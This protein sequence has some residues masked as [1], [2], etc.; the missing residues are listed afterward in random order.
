MKQQL[1]ATIALLMALIAPAFG[2]DA[3]AFKNY[4]TLSQQERQK[5]ATEASLEVQRKYKRWD[6]IISNGGEWWNTYQANQLIWFKGLNDLSGLSNLPVAL[7][8]RFEQETAEAN[9][10]SGMTKETQGAMLDSL[11]SEFRRIDKERYKDD[12]WY[13]V[14]LAPTPEAMALDEK[15]AAL[16]AEWYRRLESGQAITREDLNVVEAAVKV[17]R[18]QMRTLPQ[19]SPEQMEEG[20]AAS[21]REEVSR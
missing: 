2:D 12:W 21:S 13:L 4:K 6:Q 8:G 1:Y 18:D 3:I 19:W 14:K 16:N 7:W 15:A 11:V 9:K 17:I 10:K 20:L 5:V